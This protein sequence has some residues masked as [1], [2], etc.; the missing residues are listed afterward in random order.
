MVNCSI[1]QFKKSYRQD[2]LSFFSFSTVLKY[3][4]TKRWDTRR[5]I[6]TIK[7]RRQE[8]CRT[9]CCVLLNNPPT[10]SRAPNK[11][12][13][14]YSVRSIISLYKRCFF[15]C[16]IYYARW[17]AID[18]NRYCSL[19]A[20]CVMRACDQVLTSLRINRSGFDKFSKPLQPN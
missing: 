6:N 3:G 4:N 14:S 13:W 8:N 20:N 11:P 16:V 19:S 18:K 7:D 9:G 10:V 12:D 1:L 2:L 5:I 15:N 17:R